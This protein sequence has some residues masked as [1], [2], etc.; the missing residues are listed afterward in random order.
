MPCDE[1]IIE[2]PHV[3]GAYNYGISKK[4]YRSYGPGGS[5]TPSPG[6]INN[7]EL[8]YKMEYGSIY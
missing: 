6:W 1:W 2:L 4:W 7:I 8:F 3:S 5:Y